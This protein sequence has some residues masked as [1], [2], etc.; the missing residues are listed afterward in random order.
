M[1]CAHDVAVSKQHKSIS[2][3]DVL[4]ALELIEFGDLVDKLQG[5][6]VVY[7]QQAK[8]DKTKKGTSNIGSVSAPVGKARPAPSPAAGSASV[9]ASKPKGKE[10]VVAGQPLPPPF[11]SAPL[12][13]S[14]GAGESASTAGAR[15]AMEVDWEEE[16]GEAAD[17]VDT[18]GEAERGGFDA[19]D[20]EEEL[21]GA[22]DDAEEGMEDHD[23]EADDDEGVEGEVPEYPMEVEEVEPTKDAPV[24]SLEEPPHNTIPAP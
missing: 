6:L 1:L 22:A 14:Y 9:A 15:M 18:E 4:K 19:E 10:K 16:L 11:T 12:A 8:T 24:E 13:Q 23:D 7:R 20:L 21:E 3:S 5:E 17:A 2:A